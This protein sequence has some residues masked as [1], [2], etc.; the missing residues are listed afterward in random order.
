M[1]SF[2]LLGLIFG[3]LL[4]CDELCDKLLVFVVFIL[5][6]VCSSFGRDFVDVLISFLLLLGLNFWGDFARLV[7]FFSELFCFWFVDFFSLEGGFFL[8]YY[9]FGASTFWGSWTAVVSE[10]G[11]QPILDL[12]LIIL[13]NK[14][15][16][17][18]AIINNGFH[19]NSFAFFHSRILLL[20]LIRDFVSKN[21]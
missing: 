14:L 19:Y 15:V 21:K 4:T 12:F 7:D 8:V 11:W 6:F 5:V 1:S 16:F 18:Q 3:L 20:W 13:L 2:T 17:T 10:E 9:C